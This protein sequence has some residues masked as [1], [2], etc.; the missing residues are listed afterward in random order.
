MASDPRVT[1]PPPPLLDTPRLRLRPLVATDLAFLATMLGDPRV[2]RF[3]P[4]PLNRAQAQEWLERQ[5]A[6]YAADGHGF[7]LVEA[8]ATGARSKFGSDGRDMWEHRAWAAVPGIGD[9]YR[10]TWWWK[11]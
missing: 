9:V 2:M 4:A 6:R 5:W 1:H 11:P 7:W 8:R 10:S 3:Y